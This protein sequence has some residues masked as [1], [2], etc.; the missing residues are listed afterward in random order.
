MLCCELLDKLP[1]TLYWS[2]PNHLYLGAGDAYKKAYYIARQKAMG[3]NPGATDLNILFRNKHGASVTLLCELKIKPN[4]PSPEQNTFMDAANG[5]GA[6]TGVAYTFDEF[7]ALLRAAGHMS[8][9]PS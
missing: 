8:I 5:L 1:G 2:T 3:L 4:K 7:M 9:P 6:Y